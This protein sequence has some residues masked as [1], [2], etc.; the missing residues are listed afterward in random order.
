VL[1]APRRLT[2][3]SSSSFYNNNV[4]FRIKI[5]FISHF[6][7]LGLVKSSVVNSSFRQKE[8]LT[9]TKSNQ[10]KKNVFAQKFEV[11]Q[12]NFDLKSARVPNYKQW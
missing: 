5:K 3:K 8:S 2:V 11:K 6:I 9:E 10:H 7:N 4:K 12:T 1:A